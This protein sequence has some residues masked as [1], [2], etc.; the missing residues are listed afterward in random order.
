MRGAATLAALAAAAALLIPTVRH[1]REEPPA[2]PPAI[3][4]AM[5]APPGTELG[6][7]DEPLDLAISP[8]QREVVFVATARRRGTGVQPPAGASQLWRRRLDAERTDAIPRTE[9]AQQPAWKQTGNVLSFFA[10]RRLKLLNLRSGA[11]GDLAGAPMPAGA[12]WLADGSLLFVPGPGPIRRQLK[13][14]TGDATRLAPGDVAHLFPSAVGSTQD[15]VYVAVRDDGRRVVRLNSN[16]AD[17]DLGTTSAH[18][19]LAGPDRNWLLTVRDTTLM[20]DRLNEDG[21]SLTGLDVP[22]ALD[23]GTTRSGRGLFAATSDVLVYANAAERAR[24]I[25]WLDM[26]GT[27][28][29]TVADAGD[30]WQVRLA[31]DDSRLAVTARDPLLRSLDV[32]MIPVST[33]LPSLRL[34]TSVAADTDPVWSRDG[35]EIA[36][37]S[38]QRGRPEVLATPAALSDGNGEPARPLRTDGEVPTDWRG[39]ELLVQ[40][41]SNVGFDLIRVNLA[42]GE[43]QPIAATPFNETDARWSPDGQWIAYVSDEPG[44]PDIYLTNGRG[45]RQRASLGGG[46][47]PRWTADGQALLFLRGSTVMR[48]VRSAGRFGA[49]EPLF[50]LPGVR[51]FDTAHRSNRIV[52]LLPAQSESVDSV[53]VV[54]N[55]QS[56]LRTPNPER[57]SRNRTQNTN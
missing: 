13:G 24:R 18:A 54:L 43:A 5:I 21:S 38:M 41:R 9:N 19:L 4:L 10:D 51:D 12:T 52:A 31:P 14:Q 8:D 11:I 29:G 55:W 49:P 56:L 3:R 17:R 40:R 27:P 28:A 35:R 32:L 47:R 53:S 34:T 23:V 22:L 15:F 6:T 20:A 39:T 36:F 33:A 48:V 2:P 46:T 45:E 30:Y 37:R 25:I 44:Q 16:G 1:L 26:Q 7:G 50:E 57:R 42:N